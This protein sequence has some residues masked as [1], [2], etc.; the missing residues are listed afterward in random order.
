MGNITVR[1]ESETINRIVLEDKEIVL[2]GTAHISAESAQEVRDAIERELPDHVSIE[3]DAGRY[4]T[5]EEGSNLKNMD[6]SKIIRER[7]TFLI[8]ANLVLSSFQQKMGADLGTRSGDEMR[9]AL[10]VAKEKGLS[11]S[12][13]DRPIQTTLQR[14]WAKC[15]LWNKL[16]LISVLISSAFT[17]E[18]ISEEE[19]EELK[20]NSAI[21]NMMGE[22][23]DFLPP[24]KEVLIDER[25][26]YL[27]TNIFKS[28]GKKIVAVIGAGHAPGL[29]GW[30]EKLV[31]EEASVS[32][33]DISHVPPKKKGAKLIPWIIPLLIATLFVLGGVRGWDTLKSMGL[34]W[35]LG[36]GICAA[37]GSIL[38][39]ARPQTILISFIAAP[40]TSMNPTIGVGF[41]TGLL[42]YFFRKPKVEDLENLSKDTATL[43]G[44]YHN[45]V[46][47]VLLVFFLSSLGSS[48]GTFWA[49]ARI[50]MIFAG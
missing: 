41:V 40:I 29:I 18:K 36:N 32:L 28:T 30:L 22:L 43:K 1:N 44:W 23:A 39:L 4:K 8:L 27:A 24:V 11:F 16:K 9:V 38:A 20:K 49:G 17:N 26:Q 50:A 45:R 13:D 6:L 5:L 3:L 14:A 7:K 2:I 31:N 46:T 42:E 35:I 12:L 37:V 19:L 34:A 15:N 47:R 21:E 10:D 25:D 33:E 48:I